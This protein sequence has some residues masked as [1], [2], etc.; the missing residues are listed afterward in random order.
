[1]ASPPFKNKNFLFYFIFILNKNLCGGCSSPPPLHKPTTPAGLYATKL[2]DWIWR[3]SSKKKKYIHVL[4]MIWLLLCS[5][6][7]P[8]EIGFTPLPTQPL[9]VW[10]VCWIFF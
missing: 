7:E 5:C 3:H 9:P 8:R 10:P 6:I 2:D 1:M 4:Y